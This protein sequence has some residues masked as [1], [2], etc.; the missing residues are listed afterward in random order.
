AAGMGLVSTAMDYARFAEM[1]RNGGSLD[2]VRI[3][4]PKT[5]NFMVQD[6]LAS[7][8]GVTGSGENPADAWSESGYGFGLGFGVITNP[9]A[10]GVV[11]SIGEYSWGG[12]AGTIFWV[13]PEEE[14]VV[15]SLIQLMNSPWSLR[16]DLK[17]ATYQALNE[18]YTDSR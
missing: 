7:S 12:A 17:V 15:V 18:T 10:Y 13:D 11:G 8:L 4:S 3:L 9:V 1:V 16:S 2:G 6:H 14:L 5:V